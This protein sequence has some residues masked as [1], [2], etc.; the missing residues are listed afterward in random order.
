MEENQINCIAVP[1]GYTYHFDLDRDIGGSEEF[2]N[3]FTILREA[4]PED[5]IYLH[6]NSPGGSLDT[7]VQIINAIGSTKATVVTSAE[8]LVASGAAVVFFSGDAFQVGSHCEFLVHTG[9]SGSIGKVSDHLSAAQFA[10]ERIRRLYEDVLGGFLTEE[11]LTS[12]SRGEEF[13]MSSE[14]VVERIQNVMEQK[15]EETQESE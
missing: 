15:E 11:E 10:N 3:F 4:S 9:S 13:F 12:I 1:N 8:G 5:I 6:I 14:D 7:T 2:T